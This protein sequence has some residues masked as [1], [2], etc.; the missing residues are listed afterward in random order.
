MMRQ[1]KIVLFLLLMG[2]TG[3]MFN[4]ANAVECHPAYN[5]NW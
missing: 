4:S 2:A 5:G 3:M 1:I